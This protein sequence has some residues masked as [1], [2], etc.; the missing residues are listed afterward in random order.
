MHVINLLL[1]LHSFTHFT[2]Y[3]HM[4]IFIPNLN[5]KMTVDWSKR[6]SRLAFIFITKSITKNLLI[7]L[8]KRKKAT[9]GKFRL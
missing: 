5:L 2:T 1:Y 3:I 4:L 9:C 6:H 8:R 7:E